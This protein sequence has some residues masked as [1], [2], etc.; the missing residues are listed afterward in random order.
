MIHY[1]DLLRSF[2]HKYA[3]E[4]E[5]AKFWQRPFIIIYLIQA[6]YLYVFGLTSNTKRITQTGSEPEP[7]PELKL[8]SETKTSAPETTS[9]VS[10]ST[11]DAS[12]ASQAAS[13]IPAV[14]GSEIQ[15]LLKQCRHDLRIYLQS[16]KRIK[17]TYTLLTAP[18]FLWLLTITAAS[19]VLLTANWRKLWLAEFEGV[20]KQIKDPRALRDL[21]LEIRPLIL[22]WML[23]APP[24]ALMLMIYNSLSDF[25]NALRR[26]EPVDAVKGIDCL[27]LTQFPD[28]TKK[29]SNIDFYHSPAFT[30]VIMSIFLIGIPG[31]IMNEIYFR[32]GLDP[33]LVSAPNSGLPSKNPE[34]HWV[35]Q[36]IQF[37][38]SPLGWCL[39]A[40]FFRSYFTFG[41]N[42]VSREH[43][44]EIYDDVV[45]SLPIKG[46]FRDAFFMRLEHIPFQIAWTDV[47]SI[48]Y[49]A[50]RLPAKKLKGK[51]PPILYPFER[52]SEMVESISKNFE[53]RSDLLEIKD[54]K[55]T[56]TIRLAD[57][58]KDEKA[59]LFCSLRKYAPSIHMDEE[60]QEALV[61]SSVLR[62]P[63]YTEI[64]F[65]V[66]T[67]TKPQE[68]NQVEAG[69]ELRSGAFTV[70]ERI[71]SGGQ[72]VIFLAED[73][74][75]NNATGNTVILKEYQ[76]V[77]G[78]SLDVL[79]ESARS[80]ENESKL[81]SQLSNDKVVKLKELF[82]ENSRVYLVL[83]HIKGPNLRELI[84]RD[85]PLASEKVRELALQMCDIL[86]Y[87]HSHVPPIVHRDFTPDNLILQD[88]G[89]LKL[90]DFSVAQSGK[91]IRQGECAGKHSYSP[92]EQFRA[93][94]VPQSDIYALGC[95]L[96]YL[97]TGQDP[98]PI[99]SSDPS[100]NHPEAAEIGKIIARATQLDLQ[101]RYESIDWV[102]TD[103]Q[104][105]DSSDS[106][107]AS[108]ESLECEKEEDKEKKEEEGLLV[109]L[110][111][112]AEE[113]IQ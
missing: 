39:S 99:S 83:E 43:D 81:L 63:K 40:L 72:A 68:L 48:K 110:K 112:E 17:W 38:V 50:A 95:T 58:S 27:R 42:F 41:W 108:Q 56:L 87:L 73:N 45:K 69:T 46:W 6:V 89:Q 86:S 113:L 37:Y 51:L 29:N 93:E 82:Y 49:H 5:E 52:L 111:Q 19:S 34:F 78:E 59:Q 60:T 100:E 88:N 76:L 71:G 25:W 22:I 33:L 96:Y 44:I 67:S 74:R 54:S 3:L 66:L 97:L 7:A 103:L 8:E 61:G 10:E 98:E 11:V 94:A 23:M 53:L 16:C 102:R 13:L 26:K 18:L 84:E 12:E 90:I 30:L 57:L 65:D 4:I 64:W 70:K 109:S 62:E 9:N 14:D 77:P 32:F 104:S 24:T 92:P 31:W 79:M 75:E 106:S 105:S 20:R 80:F 15:A 107:H 28:E 1:F 21:A 35:I 101:E 2:C 85:G 47:S 36:Q 91:N 55:R